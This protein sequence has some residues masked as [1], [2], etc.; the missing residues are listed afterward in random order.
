MGLPSAG[1][2]L[3]RED[4][5]TSRTVEACFRQQSCLRKASAFSALRDVLKIS[6]IWAGV[7]YAFWGRIPSSWTEENAVRN[8]DSQSYVDTSIKTE[9]KGNASSQGSANV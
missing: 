6:D 7:A 4:E 1:E 5:R 8:Q 9:I 3:P 2:T